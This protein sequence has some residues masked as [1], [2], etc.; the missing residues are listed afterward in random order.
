MKYCRLLWLVFQFRKKVDFKAL[1]RKQSLHVEWITRTIFL[2]LNRA[3][4]GTKQCSNSSIRKL[5]TTSPSILM[6]R[7]AMFCLRAGK[8]T[9]TLIKIHHQNFISNLLCLW[10]R[11]QHYNVPDPDPKNKISE[12][13]SNNRNII[14]CF[15]WRVRRYGDGTKFKLSFF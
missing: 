15:V 9:P 10:T 2:F 8:G 4:I 3:L 14:W 6:Y 5:E 12:F 11:F 7:E 1:Q 13:A